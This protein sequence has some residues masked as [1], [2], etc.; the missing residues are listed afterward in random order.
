[1]RQFVEAQNN[2]F[3]IVDKHVKQRVE[4]IGLLN[5]KILA[6]SEKAP[7]KVD[8]L[9]HLI[10]EGTQNMEDVTM[11]VLDILTGGGETV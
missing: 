7:P 10:H 4:E 9:T 1:M 2:V 5:E 8:L 3:R 11:S 6:G